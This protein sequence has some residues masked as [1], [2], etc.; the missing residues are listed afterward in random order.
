MATPKTALGDYSTAWGSWLTN[1]KKRELRADCLPVEGIGLD[2]IQASK[3]EP[4]IMRYELTDFEW[5]GIRLF[6]PNKPYGIPRVDD[7]HTVDAKM[8]IWIKRRN[9]G[10]SIDGDRAIAHTALAGSDAASYE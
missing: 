4:R 7:Q 6:L 5:A 8:L 2:V 3:A 9:V 1:R 10:S